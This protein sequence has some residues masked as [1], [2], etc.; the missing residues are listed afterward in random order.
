MYSK[1]LYL[2]I[3]LDPADAIAIVLAYSAR[4]SGEIQAEA[5]IS[6]QKYRETLIAA[7]CYKLHTDK[8]KALGNKVEADS[9]R[10]R[11]LVANRIP[12]INVGVKSNHGWSMPVLVPSETLHI[13]GTKSHSW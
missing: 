5:F 4:R 13:S 12:I 11:G 2:P 8:L 1:G 7:R 9:V 6:E 3:T 10:F